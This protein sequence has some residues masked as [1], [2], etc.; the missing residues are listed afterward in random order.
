M[1]I[2]A[3]SSLLT[4]WVS[5]E[6]YF[7]LALGIVALA[8]IRTYAQGR[9]TT[10]ERDLHDRTVLITGAFTPLGLTL[11]EALAERGARI[12]ALS[13]AP[14]PAASLVSLIRQRTANEEIFAEECDLSS[15]ASIVEFAR[16]MLT[17]LSDSGADRP[18]RL[19]AIVFAHEYA[20]GQDGD[21]GSRA[22]FLLTTLLLPG[23]ITSPSD[24]DIRILF[25]VNPLYAAQSTKEGAR[26][27]R[28]VVLARHLQRVLDALPTEA[29][30]PDAK[31]V[32]PKPEK[33]M[34][35]TSNIS[36]VS[37]S[38]GISRTDTIAPML[39]AVHFAPGGFS[40]IGLVIYILLQPLLRIFAKTPSNAI[41]TVLHALFL[42][43]SISSSAHSRSTTPTAKSRSRS[44]D[45]DSAS[46]AEDTEIL[47]PGALYADCGILP[48][49]PDADVHSE[50]AGVQ[51]WESLERALKTWAVQEEEEAHRSRAPSVDPSVTSTPAA[52]DGGIS[53]VASD[54][55][56]ASLPG[57]LKK[58][59]T[60]K[61][62]KVRWADETHERDSSNRH[63]NGN[64][65]AD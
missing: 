41:Q 4:R 31:D 3:T 26:A 8:V 20:Y 7:P 12:I 64:G 36:A 25:I 45:R 44:R 40:N 19:D 63:A 22:S 14:G 47:L 65:T 2:N 50:P 62:A 43:R 33:P 54:A 11:V 48:F 38:P 55:D 13:D 52:T 17:R 35:G 15:R 58:R 32:Q 60:T 10:R 61:D 42:P 6:Y 46:S 51:V 56:V 57:G 53:R 39:G 1:P 9:R 30:V 18:A 34:Q 23:L 21:A 28:M 29:P 59:K 5:S 27:R 24:R 16:Q 49:P 37:V